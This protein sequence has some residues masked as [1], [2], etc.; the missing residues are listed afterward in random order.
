VAA[1]LGALP[2][3]DLQ[4]RHDGRGDLVWIARWFKTA[5]A[6]FPTSVPS[7][8]IDQLHGDATRCPRAILEHVR[9]RV[10]AASSRVKR[11]ALNE[12]PT[13]AR[14]RAAAARGV[15]QFLGKA[16]GRYS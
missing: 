12:T 4:F 16:V 7:I 3:T 9:D 11:L 1:A 2:A 6:R 5:V 14:S 8:S 15:Q 13:S 10:A